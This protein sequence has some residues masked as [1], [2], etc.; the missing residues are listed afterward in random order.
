MKITLS[1]LSLSFVGVLSGCSPVVSV[2]PLYT[3]AE[4]QNPYL[5]Q[6]VEGEW[7]MANLDDSHENAA[8]PKP[9]CRVSISKSSASEVPYAVE[10]RCPGSEGDAGEEYSKYVFSLVSLGTATFFDAR[11]AESKEKEKHIS[12]GEITDKGIISGHL[13]GQVWVQQDFVRF[14]PLQSDWVEKN[15]PGNF[16]A[17]SKV[18]KYDKVDVLTN[19]TPD[20]RDLFS[21]NAGSPDALSFP[22]FLCRAGADCDARAMEDQ[23]TRTPNSQEVLDGAVKFYAKRGNF[24]RAISLQRHKIELDSDA[25]ADQFTL[26]RL[27]LLTRDFDGARSALVVAKEPSERPSIKELVVRSHFLQG[28]YAG[29]VQAAKFLDAPANLS[30]A[31]PIIL[32]YF[33]LN[34]LGRVKGAES[35]LREQASTFVG[36]AQEQL[37]LLG[38]L[39]RVTDSLSSSEDQ[40]RSTYYYALNGLRNG[41]L[42]HC[43]G[44]LQDLVKMRPKDDLIGLAAQ[45]EFERLPST[46]NK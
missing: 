11:F 12:L 46:T 15:W 20:L 23:L 14:T 34:R 32:S 13:L 33:A 22:L 8:T 27:L 17:I 28:N 25:A 24:A 9:P 6:R 31:D 18:G 16:L 2:Q 41:D 37:F 43:R 30:S 29:A 3:Q 10:F 44:H 7:I 45:I 21:R 39:G 40:S 38:I 19:P 1:V 36:P 42:E 26:G 4:I 5:N 35:Y